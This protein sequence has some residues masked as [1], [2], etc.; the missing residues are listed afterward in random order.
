MAHGLV[1]AGVRRVRLTGGEPLLHP[2][3]VEMVAYVASLGVDDLA[4][5]TNG[6]RLFALAPRLKSAGLRRITISLDSLDEARFARITRGGDLGRVV[7]G[8]H[9]AIA[10]GFEEVKINCVVLKGENDAELPAITRW[11]WSLGIVPRFIELMPIAE[12]ANIIADKLVTANGMRVRLADMLEDEPG[13]VDPDRGPARY[14]RSRENPNLRVG[15]ITGTSD[16]FCD[17]CDRLR[18][19]ADGTLRACLATNAA[20]GARDLA[21]GG[22]LDGIARAVD[23]AWQQKPD[24]RVWKGCTEDTA[25]QVSMR[26]IGG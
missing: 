21:A 3:A 14:V 19:A 5:T 25:A 2:R 18:V 8:I 22:D 9:A 4:L 13:T 12:G 10:A 26:A 24:G 15:F 1:R 6:T 16:T 20:V 23:L 11:A 7:A 17:Q